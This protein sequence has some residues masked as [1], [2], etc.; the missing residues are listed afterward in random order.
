ML[1][2][3]CGLP[4]GQ[5]RDSYGF[6]MPNIGAAKHPRFRQ[7]RVHK[8]CLRSL[9][10]NRRERYAKVVEAYRCRHPIASSA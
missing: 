8:S 1:C 7:V 3:M 6:T 2:L 10:R 4:T 9:G 5:P